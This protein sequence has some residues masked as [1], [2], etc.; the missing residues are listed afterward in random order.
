MPSHESLFVCL[1]LSHSLNTTGGTWAGADRANSMVVAAPSFWPEYPTKAKEKQE[2][3]K[4]FDSNKKSAVLPIKIPK[5]NGWESTS[6]R[7]QKHTA[8]RGRAG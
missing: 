1:L 6:I 8:I 7:P 4:E 5:A 2:P 3:Q